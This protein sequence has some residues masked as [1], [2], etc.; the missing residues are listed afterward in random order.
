LSNSQIFSK[1]I[2]SK[3]QLYLASNKP[4]I[5]SL[6]GEAASIITKSGSG[7]VSNAEDA[8][9]LAKNCEIISNMSKCQL[10]SMGNNGLNYFNKNFSDEVFM[11][12]FIKL[13][14]STYNTDI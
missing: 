9:E 13:V 12:T 6:N 7:Y 8:E 1:T 10:Q 5:G 14:N 3:L 11:N 4:I 2:P